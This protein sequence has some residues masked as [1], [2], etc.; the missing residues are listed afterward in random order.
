MSKTIEVKGIQIKY[1]T[2]NEDDFLSLTDLA[3]FKSETPD[4]LIERWMRTRSAIDYLAVWETLYNPDFDDTQL[5]Q[6]RLESSEN[7]FSLSP[8]R[9]ARDTNAIGLLVKMGRS[10]GTFAHK[11]IAFKFAS[12]LSVEFELF[13]IKE[14]QRLKSEEQQKLAWSAKRELARINYHIQTDAIKTN[15]IVPELTARQKSFVYADEADMLNVALFG[16]TAAEWRAQ[17]PNLK[18]NIRDY[19]TLHQLLVLANMESS[20]A[21]MLHEKMPQ[22][23]RIV[24]L[25]KMAKRQLS[26]LMETKNPLLLDAES[27]NIEKKE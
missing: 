18:G 13:V 3:K 4:R 22:S 14:F 6:I 11:D 26:V 2:I 15:L 19:S 7:T 17:N 24:R 16:K 1:R 8:T 5:N 21:E 12:W 25:N 23:E 10:G 27:P 9:W 20:N